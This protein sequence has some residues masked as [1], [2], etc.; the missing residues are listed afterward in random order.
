MKRGCPTGEGEGAAPAGKA[1]QRSVPRTGAG[2]F[3]RFGNQDIG[4]RPWIGYLP[5]RQDFLAMIINTRQIFVP[6]ARFFSISKIGLFLLRYRT[7]LR[8]LALVSAQLSSLE[9]YFN[10]RIPVMVS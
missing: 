2:A 7:K 1:A 3:P 4:F 9:I 5:I 8:G 10:L 6:P